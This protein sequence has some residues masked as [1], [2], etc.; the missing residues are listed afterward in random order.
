MIENLSESMYYR[1]EEIPE[2]QA[3]LSANEMLVPVRVCQVSKNFLLW[4]NN[5]CSNNI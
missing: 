4:M 3:H 2:D 1:I 5:L